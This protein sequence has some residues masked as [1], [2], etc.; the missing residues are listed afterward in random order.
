MLRGIHYFIVALYVVLPIAALVRD[1]M[2]ARKRKGRFP[3]RG[4]LTSFSMAI[5]LGTGICLAYGLLVGGW[6][7]ISQV[8]LA[9]YF[10]AGMLLLLKLFDWS[11]RT[12]LL[13]IAT[14]YHGPGPVP[15]RG[16]MLVDWI[17]AGTRVAILVAVGLP[18]IMA[19]AMTYRPKVHVADDPKRQLGYRYEPV[20]FRST[21]GIELAGWWIPGFTTSR[22]SQVKFDRTVIICHG[23]AAN[24]S[25]QLVMSRAFVPDGYNVLIFD[26]RAHG[27]SGGQLSS[28]GDLERFDVLGAVRWLK[29]NRPE[30]AK[31]IYGVG[32]SMG[33][34]ALIGAA[35][36]PSDEGRAIDAVAV[37]DTFESL[38]KLTKQLAR[39]KF[40]PP[41]NWVVSQ[42]ALPLASI[43]VGAN[44]NDFIPGNLVQDVWPRP[45]MIIHGVSDE[46][47]E[48][49]NGINLFND[50]SAPKQRLWINGANHNS[51]IEDDNAANAIRN[52][53]ETA[54]PMQVI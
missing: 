48:F 44:L 22:N 26:F 17:A 41:L 23:L 13:K 16:S 10:A 39:T 27:D 33:A 38:P 37:Y 46:I 9:C 32:I 1:L 25:N 36:E 14:G 18:Y 28:L 52:F 4:L 42:F 35:A 30:Q 2:R 3:S 31:K 54:E 21:D 8:A 19:A 15:R 49:Q 6:A 47:I 50:A 45:V 40:V 51:V 29:Q 34:A 5:F 20:A 12:S 53:F 11:L 7:R 43:Q 24:K